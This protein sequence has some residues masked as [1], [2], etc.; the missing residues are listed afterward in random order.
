MA[1]K[2][3]LY[4][5]ISA[6]SGDL[7]FGQTD[8]VKPDSIK[9][10]ENIQTFS[11]KRNFTKLMYSLIFNPVITTPPKKKPR[12]KSKNILIQKP[13]SA[14]EGKI[15]RNITIES[16]D[17]FGYS[18]TDT[19]AKPQ[20]F[21]SKTGNNFHI[22]SRDIT[23][24]NLL[25]IRPNQAFDSLRVKE[26]E[27]LIRNSTYMRDVSFFVSS[28]SKKSDSVD[29]IIRS[30]DRWSLTPAVAISASNNAIGLTDN[31]FLGLGHKFS[32]GIAW[33]KNTPISAFNTNYYIPN[34][35]NT[36]VSTNLNYVRDEFGNYAK[37]VTI[38]RPFFSPFAKW[39]AGINFSQDYL[40]DSIFTT[41]SIYLPRKFKYNT[42]DYWAG[43]SIQIFKGSSEN[44][45]T[46]NFISAFRVLRI[47]YL[48]R[49]MEFYHSEY[50]YSN[51]NFYLASIGISTRKYVQDKYIF[52][53]GITEDIPVGRVFSITGGIQKKNDILRIYIGGRISEGNY[54]P[55]GY[56]SSSFEYGTF[57]NGARTE[58]GAIIAGINYYTSLFEIRKWKF[59]QFVKPQV[60]IG[61]DRFSNDSI[62]LNEGYGLDG[63]KSKLLSGSSRVLLTLQTQSYSP[64]NVFGF[65]FGPYLNL[66]FGMLG[67]ETTSFSNSKVYSQIGLGVLIKN[68]NLIINTFQISIAFYPLAPNDGQNAFRTNTFK[69]NDFGF[70]DFEIGKPAIVLFQ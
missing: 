62:N 61:I 48:E 64:W 16:L 5:I 39:A 60:T 24:L 68:D 10:Y 17:P 42:L 58:Q 30:L 13:Y 41:D 69:T 1:R 8:P 46:T 15:I 25:L 56:F 9:L 12:K 47:R 52:K 37:N 4:I 6:L 27:R 33:Y 22:K 14:F 36:Y 18:I 51:E 59:R 45:R 55:W 50:K 53:Y 43:S 2:L 21:L 3:L 44:I 54:Y 31:N 29:I 32:N 65:R 57:F 63:F 49:P 20:N 40:R 26:S 28:I 7:L 11:S 38:D 66:S 70:R 35:W 19:T 23:I 67:N 34:I